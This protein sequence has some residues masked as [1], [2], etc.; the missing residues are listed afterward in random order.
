MASS[1]RASFWAPNVN[2]GANLFLC[3]QEEQP[4]TNEV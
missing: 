4:N 1:F 2:K 3:Q